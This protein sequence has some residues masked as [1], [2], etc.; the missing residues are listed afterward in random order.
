MRIAIFCHSIRSDWNHGNAHFLRGVSVALQRQRH[1]VRLFEPVDGWSAVSLEADEG[2]AALEAYR[3]RYPTLRPHVYDAATFDLER[4]VDGA[5][6]VLVH[7]WNPPE[8]I[9]RLASMR[10]R[11]ARFTLLFHDTHHRSL[12]QADTITA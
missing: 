8:L 1:E 7:E 10:R 12:S 11:G 6:V 5:S 9:S 2:S 3:D 4:A